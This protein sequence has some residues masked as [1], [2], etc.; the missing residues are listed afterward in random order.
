MTTSA[1]RRRIPTTRAVI[2][3]DDMP[4]VLA[5]HDAR[6]AADAALKARV[7]AL[8]W[9]IVHAL[10]ALDSIESMLAAFPSG[11]DY[12]ADPDNQSPDDA[13]A[14]LGGLMHR[15]VTHATQTLRAAMP[16]E[17]E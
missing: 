1:D 7:D 3:Q 9:A 16:Q 6:V 2:T 11:L 4:E 17:D 8:E 15:E 13:F 12:D 5:R 10:K 14:H